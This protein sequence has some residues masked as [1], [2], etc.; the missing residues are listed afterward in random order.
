MKLPDIQ[1]RLVL[2]QALGRGLPM[3]APRRGGDPMKSSPTIFALLSAATLGWAGGPSAI[4]ATPECA[5]Q[6]G[7]GAVDAS[8]V[9]NFILQG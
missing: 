3:R 5:D 2:P 9:V 7:D 8:D 4:H 1:T 6:N